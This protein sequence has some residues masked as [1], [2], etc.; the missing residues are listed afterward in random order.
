MSDSN[1]GVQ[2][3]N[4]LA[5]PFPSRKELHAARIPQRPAG[6]DAG[7]PEAQLPE[8]PVEPTS[9]PPTRREPPRRPRT[10]QPEEVQ[11][12]TPVVSE[13]E[14]ADWA[15]VAEPEAPAAPES[16]TD[17]SAPRFPRV[18]ESGPAFESPF[19]KR[20]SPATGAQPILP[21]AG[22][23][24]T[25]VATKKKKSRQL[26]R[27]LWT[28]LIAIVILAAI[29]VGLW[30]ALGSLQGG[31][32]LRAADDYPAVDLTGPEAANHPTVEVT[33]E[34]GAL[35][36]EIGQALVDADVVK[37]VAAFTRAFDANPAAA[38]IKPGTYTLH[39]Q[40][41]AVDALAALLD[42]TNRKENTIT[43]NP[44]QTV[45]QIAEKL[46]TVAGFS[47][48]EVNA[49]V[50]DPSG[51]TDLPAAAKGNLEGWLWPGSYDFSPT[52]TPTEV[53]SE[54]VKGTVDY[55]KSE[56][57]PEDKWQETLIK[58][59][60]VEREVNREE[61][62]PKVARVIENRIADPEGPTRGMLQMDSTVAYGVGGT[63]GL[64]DSAAF[65]DDNPYN[66]YKVKG[67]P[68]GPIASPSAAA[69]QAVLH[70]AEGDWLYFVTVNLTTGETVFTDSHDELQTLTEQ[71]Q[72][73]CEEN[74][75][76][77]RQ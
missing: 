22:P 42:E 9:T 26:R 52:S 32:G 51:V 74:P 1:N 17:E 8:A 50:D 65:D 48:D 15:P 63:G 58:A 60:I 38:S 19:P 16:P 30:W 64:P 57:V 46:E 37:S 18:T 4:R 13:A 70:P 14:P 21:A 23:R 33:V 11:V 39:T 67:L 43:V 36:S 20:V 35:G 10:V 49:V 27:R 41:P 55:L 66:T 40:I 31:P 72:Q 76:E 47:A 24:Q 45:S 59:S 56:G 77:C 3:P 25:E 34:P 29:G 62:M 6:E 61:D 73:W 2:P 12:E 69:I 54:M 71:L 68:A 28:A 44:G 5:P 7:A 75:G 53:F